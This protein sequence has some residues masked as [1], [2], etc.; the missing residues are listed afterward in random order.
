MY[1]KK[2]RMTALLSNATHMRA[3]QN[4]DAKSASNEWRR[5]LVRTTWLGLTFTRIDSD[6]SPT[7]SKTVA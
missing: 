3:V 5:K 6:T 1:P 2:G 4:S 7:F